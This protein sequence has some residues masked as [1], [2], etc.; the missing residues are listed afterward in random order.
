MTVFPIEPRHR[1]SYPKK[2]ELIDY[3]KQKNC[4]KNASECFIMQL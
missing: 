3:K 2:D 4:K 1:V